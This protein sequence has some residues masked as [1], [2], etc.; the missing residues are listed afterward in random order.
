MHYCLLFAGTLAW[1][2]SVWRLLVPGFADANRFNNIADSIQH[3]PD[4]Q[5]DLP[6]MLNLYGFRLKR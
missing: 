6:W 2:E 1:P 4:A 5:E 3:R